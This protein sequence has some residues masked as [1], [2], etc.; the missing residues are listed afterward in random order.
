MNVRE[1]ERFGFQRKELGG[2]ISQLY[3][4]FK[5]RPE[6]VMSVYGK[7]SHSLNEVF[8]IELRR[9]I[10]TSAISKYTYHVA[11]LGGKINVGED[12]VTLP[13]HL[14]VRVNR[15]RYINHIHPNPVKSYYE[16]ASLSKWKTL[17]SKSEDVL[18]CVLVEPPSSEK[19]GSFSSIGIY[20]PESQWSLGENQLPSNTTIIR[21]YAQKFGREIEK[22]ID[23]NISINASI[24]GFSKVKDLRSAM[25]EELGR[26]YELDDAYIRRINQLEDPENIEKV[27]FSK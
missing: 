14:Y 10:A 22:V 17:N 27:A 21:Q 11:D 6:E 8:S 2:M 13:W 19:E 26:V 15:G 12:T 3:H 5:Y 20:L 24:L 23:L 1:E 16:W 7:E 4:T 9:I 18:G 25:N